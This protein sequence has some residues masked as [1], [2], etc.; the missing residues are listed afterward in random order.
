[1]YPSKSE[2]EQYLWMDGVEERKNQHDSAPQLFCMR[3]W[4]D[5]YELVARLVLPVASDSDL[6]RGD[7]PWPGTGAIISFG[8]I[9]GVVVGV[10]VRVTLC[11]RTRTAW[12]GT[13]HHCALRLRNSETPLC[14]IGADRERHTRRGL[15]I[16]KPCI[17]SYLS[18]YSSYYVAW[19]PRKLARTAPSVGR[20]Y[21]SRIM[22]SWMTF[23]YEK[24]RC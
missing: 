15:G 22:S 18:I 23:L 19:K 6:Q 2:N 13:G 3:W 5:L 24:K 11:R 1:M 8:M 7:W 12:A 10:S 17:W 16:G 14:C 9:D 21:S 20:R 4:R